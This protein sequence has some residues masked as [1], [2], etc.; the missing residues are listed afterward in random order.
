MSNRT[1]KFVSAIF[2]G[3][4]A[5]VAL[6]TESNSA[7]PAADDCLSGP[8]NPAPEGSHW[9]YRVDRVTK[10]HCWY[11]GEEHEKHSRA[12]P[13]NSA[14][15]ENH[16]SLWKQNATQPSNADAH[17]ELPLP[18]TPL[19]REASAIAWT[20]AMVANAASA[21]NSR[22]ANNAWDADTR[23][24][25]VASRWP[26]QSGMS[27]SATPESTS[28]SSDASASDAPAQ[29]NSAASP[30]PGVAAVPLTAADASSERPFQ[31]E[32][33][34]GS[35]PMLLIIVLGAL[36]F[37]GLMGSAIFRFGNIPRPDRPRIRGDRRGIWDL[38]DA[39]RPSA[40]AH[41]RADRPQTDYPRADPSMRRVDVACEL[42]TGDDPN[43]RILEMLVRLHRSS[44]N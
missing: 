1:A 11:L 27:S 21:G 9:Y 19:K 13:Q 28:D 18:P 42:P 6:T 29:S 39:D 30:F 20:P 44:A 5:S 41:L 34:A 26:E 38:A 4:L 14:P 32:K 7:A 22:A 23:R 17:A 31:P 25:V 10:R 15:S 8:K 43:G 35:I 3:L 24:S 36:S 33:Q 37:A 12:A 40:I 2:A 16:V